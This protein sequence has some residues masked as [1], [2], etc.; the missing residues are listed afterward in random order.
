MGGEEWEGEGS[1]WVERSGRV[2]GVDGWR[3]RKKKGPDRKRGWVV[4]GI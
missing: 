2:R 3:G 1:G 4:P